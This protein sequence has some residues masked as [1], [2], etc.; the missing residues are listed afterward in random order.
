MSKIVVAALYRFTHLP[1]FQQRRQP[2]LDYCQ[3]L[4]IKG[5]LL[6]A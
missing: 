1:D 5:T 6:L 4:G 3:T 2:L